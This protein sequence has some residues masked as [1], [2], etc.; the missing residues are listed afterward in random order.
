MML[1]VLASLVA[2]SALAQTKPRKAPAKAPAKAAKAAPQPPPM[3]TVP[4]PPPA[5]PPNAAQCEAVARTA[6]LNLKALSGDYADSTLAK[7]AGQ[8]AQV[9]AQTAN[10]LAV[11]KMNL[12]LLNVNHCPTWTR[13]VGVMNYAD[14]ALAC[15][16]AA[17]AE[18][19]D[20][21]DK[22]SWKAS[23]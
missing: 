21:C 1:I 5:P 15:A 7:S 4:L 2:T 22:A 23:F 19:A 8:S 3:M 11:L 9:S 12:D 14:A 6:E 16:N 13:P 10:D 17:P 20:K 18:R